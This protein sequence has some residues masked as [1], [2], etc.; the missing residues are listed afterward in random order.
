MLTWFPLAALVNRIG[1]HPEVV[2]LVSSFWKSAGE[3]AEINLYSVCGAIKLGLISK[4]VMVGIMF[5]A[6]TLWLGSSPY[7]HH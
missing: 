2:R 7:H 6:G 4:R 3:L 5:R 1:F